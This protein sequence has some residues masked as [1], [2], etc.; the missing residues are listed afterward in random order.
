MSRACSIPGVKPE[1]LSPYCSKKWEFPNIWGRPKKGPNLWKQPMYWTAVP[2][3]QLARIAPPDGPHRLELGDFVAKL[4]RA[5]LS[6]HAKRLQHGNSACS[7]E[8]PL[9]RNLWTVMCH[10][11]TSWIQL[12]C[13]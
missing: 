4:V 11:P 3:C 13:T 7:G 1:E 12:L 6:V 8:I 10:V 5:C 9:G 2:L